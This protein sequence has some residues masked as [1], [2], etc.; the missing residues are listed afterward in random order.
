MQLYYSSWQD[1]PLEHWPWI[2]FTPYEIAVR[3]RPNRGAILINPTALNALDRL[4][5]ILAAPVILN[6][7][8]R[9]PVYNAS[10]GGAPRSKHTMGIAF[11]IQH[12][13]NYSVLT[14]VNAAKAAGFRGFGL[15]TNFTHVDMGNER[16]WH[17]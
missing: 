3:D 4:R 5:N 12:S 15:Y 11:D 9:D 1:V 16:T 2:N 14:L 10:V 13:K 17:G 7:A 6:S 8:Y